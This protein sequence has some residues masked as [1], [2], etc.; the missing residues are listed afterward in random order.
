MNQRKRAAVKRP[1]WTRL[2]VDALK[3][4]DDFMSFTQLLAATGANANQMRA[5]LH[6]LQAR[7][8]VDA[9]LVQD[10]PWWFLTGDDTRSFTTDERVPEEPGNR[11]RRSKVKTERPG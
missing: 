7:K 8:V 9:V 2:T 3:K 6:H 10:G 5:T 11:H 1:T 4:A